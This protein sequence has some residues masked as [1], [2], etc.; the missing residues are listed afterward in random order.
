MRAYSRDD[1]ERVRLQAQVRDWTRAGLIDAARG[2]AL[3]AELR[4]DLR[5]TNS[6]L[7]GVLGFFT[8]VIVAAVAGFVVAFFQ[9]RSDL[10]IAI[11]LMIAATVSIVTTERVIAAARLYRFGV[12][13]ALAMMAVAMGSLSVMLAVGALRV[14][15]V[16]YDG[17]TTMLLTFAF[18]AVANFAVFAR[19]GLVYAGA[20]SLACAALMPFQ[21]HFEAWIARIL[22]TAMLLVAFALARGHH[23]RHG[24]DY[25]GDESAVLQAAAWLGAYLVINLQITFQLL[26]GLAQSPGERWFYWTTYLLT[27]AMPAVGLWLGLREKD[28]PFIR[29]NLLLAI[30]TLATNKPYLGSP[31]H[32][33]DPMILGAV[34]VGAALLIRRLLASGQNA[35]RFGFTAS[36]ILET[37]RDVVTALGHASAVWQ[38]HAAAPPERSEPGFGGGR[39]GGGGAT[40][41]F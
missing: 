24:D 1:E 13:E 20:A 15:Q 36:S 12:E 19:Y 14:P 11:W 38:P 23:L 16:R 7:R 26:V 2:N 5:R 35:Q 30:A 39:S 27:W 29:A 40:G 17:S 4:T 33:W 8:A 18:A 9:I 22:A 25:P 10:S 31:R 21:L 6:M 41:S 3:E 37:D 28:R 34:L 32:S